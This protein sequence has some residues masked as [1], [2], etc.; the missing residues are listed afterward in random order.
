MVALVSA[1]TVL[2]VLLVVLVA[3]LLRSHAEVLRRLGP[4]V[5]SETAPVTTGLTPAAPN[6]RRDGNVPAVAI[7]GPTPSGDSISLD[8]QG[9]AA[10]PTLLAFLT[11]GCTTCA[12]FWETL[13]E[14]RLPP[15]VQTV[16]VTRGSERERPARLRSLAPTD[17]PVVMSSEAWETYAVPGAPYFVLVDRVVRGEG[18]ATTWQALASLVTD[19][20]EDQRESVRSTGTTRGERIDETLAAAGIGVD[21]PSLYPAGRVSQPPAGPSASG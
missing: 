3:G 12:G 13:G 9:G 20:I 11:T 14:P 21:H 10:G 1:E 15:G 19:A 17:V 7:A 8:F 16:I 5:E 2:L 18:V 6:S 4:A